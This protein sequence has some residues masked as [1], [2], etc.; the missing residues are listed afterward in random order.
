MLSKFY[1]TAIK[2][3]TPYSIRS[4]LIRTNLT[5]IL[6]ISD[7]VLHGHL[8]A[9]RLIVPTMKTV[10]RSY[11]IQ[12]KEKSFCNAIQNSYLFRLSIWK[13]KI[14]FANRLI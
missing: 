2:I 7:F 12:S 3:K 13:E 14:I 6:D 1:Q 8:V 5:L 10:I 9:N 11:N 4:I